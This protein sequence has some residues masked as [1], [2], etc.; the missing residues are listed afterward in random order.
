MP[1]KADLLLFNARVMTLEPSQ[2]H[3][4]TVAIRNGRIMAAG[5]SEDLDPLAGP[6][7][8][9]I[10]CHGMTLVPGFHDAHCHLLAL[11]SR[12]QQLD[13]GPAS[14]PSIADLVR[15]ISHKA[16]QTP[17]CQWVRVYGYDEHL[18]KEARHP[19]AA[20]LDRAAP[21]HP[22]RLD[23]RTGHATVLNTAAMNLLDIGPD[24]Q[25]PAHAVVLRNDSGYPT[26]V[27]LE[28]TPEIGRLMRHFRS[29]IEFEEDVRDANALLLSKGI[30]A[31]QDAGHSNGIEQWR[32]FSSLK[33]EGAL[34]P[35]VTMMAGLPHAD[36]E[37]LQHA[38]SSAYDEELRLGAV[39]VMLTSTTGALQPT[40]QELTE[41][42]IH[43][44]R[45]GRQLAFHAIEAE[46]VIAAA[47]AIAAAGRAHLN[48]DHRHRIE[49]C[50][51]G[52]TEI[53]KMVKDSGAMVVTQPG[54]IYHHGPKYLA[55]VDPGLVPH[56]Y[57]LA[58]LDNA[59][60]PWAAGSDA[61]VALPDPLLH[62]QASVERRT[63]DGRSI[64]PNQA[65]F[66][67]RALNA[68]TIDAARSCFQEKSLGSIS[69]GKFADLVLLSKDPT[70][71][72]PEE[73]GNIAVQMTIV[74][75]RIVWEA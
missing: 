15:L 19:T 13:C 41:L 74:G 44:H 5:S 28:M 20:D 10:D 23:H 54:F 59:G 1:G 42:S 72:P 7:T 52:S 58:S 17:T 48:P 16:R 12:L 49:H 36:D 31:I 45:E 25:P 22:V 21:N 14:A 39:K 55:Q 67:N 66:P 38:A 73:I 11:A 3:A 34:T 56:L 46:S 18:L 64:G 51:E 65:V 71:T 37:E 43:H 26:G 24:F 69:P 30:T 47:H 62:V 60:I 63:S 35:R 53:L 68:W 32:T 61:P 70:Q 29:L 40:L 75:G 8:K 50:A 27:F 33:Q 2:P 57:P 4:S 6:S 9:Q